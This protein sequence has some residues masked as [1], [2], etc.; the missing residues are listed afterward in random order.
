MVI[1]PHFGE[2]DHPSGGRVA[3]QRPSHPIREVAKARK[4]GRQV[5]RNMGVRIQSF[6]VLAATWRP[7]GAC[8]GR[9]VGRRIGSQRNRTGRRCPGRRSRYV[10]GS[11][12]GRFRRVSPTQAA[13]PDVKR[14]NCH[15]LGPAC[16]ASAMIAL[17][18]KT[19]AGGDQEENTSGRPNAINRAPVPLCIAGAS[20]PY[21]APAMPISICAENA[22]ITPIRRRVPRLLNTLHSRPSRL[23]D[24]TPPGMV[25]PSDDGNQPG[26][27]CR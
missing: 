6:S 15:G 25:C 9:N 10:T 18:A 17:Y 19:Q 7:R 22:V 3:K 27:L 26:S 5:S 12:G 4:W 16:P 21:P 1:I 11:P 2:E 20:L 24:S 23:D 8:V 14:S 13:T